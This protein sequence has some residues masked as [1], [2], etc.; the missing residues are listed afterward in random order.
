MVPAKTTWLSLGHAWPGEG[1]G[2]GTGY[3]P[4]RGG[5]VGL[6][7][8]KAKHPGRSAGVLTYTLA[9]ELAPPR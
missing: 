6:Y 7:P 3:G 4:T 8:G 5:H 1:H 9:R 2:A